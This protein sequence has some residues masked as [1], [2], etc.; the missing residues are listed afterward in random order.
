MMYQGTQDER[1]YFLMDKLLEGRARRMEDVEQAFKDAGIPGCRDYLKGY[2]IH[3]TREEIQGSL[4]AYDSWVQINRV[5]LDEAAAVIVEE[6]LSRYNNVLADVPI[7]AF[8]GYGPAY[9]MRIGD[10]LKYQG[11]YVVGENSDWERHRHVSRG[12]HFQS[13]FSELRLEDRNW[14]L[15]NQGELAWMIEDQ[16]MELGDIDSD[17][18][19][20]AYGALVRDR[21][22]E[23]QFHRC[24]EL[25][26]MYE[27]LAPEDIF[28]GSTGK[29]NFRVRY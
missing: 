2:G 8:R 18:L 7:N 9:R 11:I 26:N 20:A 14:L 22:T 15:G 25:V 13:G 28:K 19:W 10:Y 29:P 17:E 5:K 21:V 3:V 6:M 24:C 4:W 27:S 23:H 12:G 16:D 1:A